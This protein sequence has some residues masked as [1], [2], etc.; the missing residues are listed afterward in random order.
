[1]GI[2]LISL[3]FSSYVEIIWSKISL[4][5]GKIVP[6]V[7]MAFIY[8]FFLTPIAFLS[9]IFGA[10]TEFKTKNNSYT[11]FIDVEKSFEKE[12]FKKGW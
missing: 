8:Y 12:S 1:M 6:N 5:I 11:M 7:L 2:S 3:K 10:K 4:L 9:K